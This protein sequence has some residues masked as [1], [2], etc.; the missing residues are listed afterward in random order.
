MSTGKL[1]LPSVQRCACQKP[2]SLS[3]SVMRLPFPCVPVNV[4][5]TKTSAQT[6]LPRRCSLTLK[7]Y[8]TGYLNMDQRVNCARTITGYYIAHVKT[9]HAA[10]TR[11]PDTHADPH[12]RKDSC[13]RAQMCSRCASLSWLA[14]RRDREKQLYNICVDVMMRLTQ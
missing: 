3:A 7:N 11:Q 1:Q 14:G 4:A 9:T 10:E 8:T 13:K 6:R 2:V 12:V 5:T